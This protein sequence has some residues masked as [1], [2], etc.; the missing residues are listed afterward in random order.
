MSQSVKSNDVISEI[1]QHL[2]ELAITNRLAHQ[3]S[4]PMKRRRLF[5]RKD[6]LASDAILTLNDDKLGL[7]YQRFDDGCVFVVLVIRGTHLRTFHQP[8]EKLTLSARVR[9]YNN[10]GAPRDS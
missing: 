3:T 1:D 10:I 5:R 2:Q 9:V 8:F 4:D 7:S 6:L